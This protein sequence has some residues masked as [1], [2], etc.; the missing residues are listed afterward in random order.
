VTVA[1]ALTNT[2]AG[3]RPLDVP[4]FVAAQ[5]AGALSATLLFSWL[6]PRMTNNPPAVLM[7]PQED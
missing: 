4:A 3:V 1:R 6:S 5:F 7:K 2:F